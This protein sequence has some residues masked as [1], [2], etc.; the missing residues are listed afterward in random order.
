MPRRRTD[1]RFAADHVLPFLRNKRRLMPTDVRRMAAERATYLI[2]KVVERGQRGEP[3]HYATREVEMLVLLME[4][5][6][7]QF[8]PAEFDASFSARVVKVLP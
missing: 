7:A 5:Y 2:R 8:P 3:V 4:A 1:E 6:E